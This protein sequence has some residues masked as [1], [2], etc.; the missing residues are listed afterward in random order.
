MDIAKRA[1]YKWLRAGQPKG[2]FKDC[3]GWREV[4]WKI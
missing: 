3:N 2:V 4:N 1:Y